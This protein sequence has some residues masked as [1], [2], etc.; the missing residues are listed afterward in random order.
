M[1]TVVVVVMIAVAA[2]VLFHVVA[3]LV[4]VV[5]ATL[6]RYLHQLPIFDLMLMLLLQVLWLV[7]V[8][9]MVML[10]LLLWLVVGYVLPGDRVLYYDAVVPVLVVVVVWPLWLAAVAAAAAVLVADAASLRETGL[11]C[12]PICWVMELDSSPYSQ[13]PQWQPLQ[14]QLPP[15]LPCV[16]WAV[17]VREKPSD[18]LLVH[19]VT[20]VLMVIYDALVQQ[21]VV[22]VVAVVL[23]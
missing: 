12:P 19:L 14:Q 9:V 17:L 18:P 8:V 20:M 3:W 13:Q 2:A 22:V 10:L 23:D 16:A 6:V 11:A 5:V 4:V 7:L 21:L 15:W 1:T